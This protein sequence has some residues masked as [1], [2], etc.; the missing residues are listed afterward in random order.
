MVYTH[1]W[2]VSP[3]LEPLNTEKLVTLKYDPWGDDPVFD[4]DE[5]NLNEVWPH[6]VDQLELE[7]CFENEHDTTPHPKSKSEPE[8]YG[9]RYI[10]L[11]VTDGGRKL[12]IV[13]Q[14]LGANWVRPITAMD[15][16]K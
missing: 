11:G 1:V 4:W 12:F 15:D 5:G 7:Q 3:G 14:H 6:H 9:D 10:V 2:D 16:D 8:K 13:V